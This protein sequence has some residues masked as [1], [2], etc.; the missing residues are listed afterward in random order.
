MAA[1]LLP[2]AAV[3]FGASG[4]LTRRKLLPAFWHLWHQGRLPNG[5]ALVG[6]ARSPMTTEEFRQYTFDNVKEFSRRPPDGETWDEFARRLS[7]YQGEFSEPGAMNDFAT[8]LEKLDAEFGT[9]GR[10]VLVSSHVLHEVEGMTRRILM[11]D[12]GPCQRLDGPA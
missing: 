10:C 1:E 2:Q 6:Y 8:Y 12:H 4:D 9:E 11:M 7:Y 5:F 3:I